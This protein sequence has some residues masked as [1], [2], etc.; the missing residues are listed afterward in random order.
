MDGAKSD[1]SGAGQ[2]ADYVFVSYAR[3]DARAAQAVIGLLER[4]GFRAEYV[5]IRRQGTL[6]AADPQRAEPRVVLAAA[7]LGRARLIDNLL[8]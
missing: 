7:R 2:R 3:P 4:A 1:E 8:V 5:E 6:E